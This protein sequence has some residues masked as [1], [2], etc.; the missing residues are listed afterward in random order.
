[1]AGGTAKLQE[2]AQDCM[3][4]E[5][6]SD[7]VMIITPEAKDEALATAAQK[8]MT[9]SLMNYLHEYVADNHQ[10]LAYLFAYFFCLLSWLI[11]YFLSCLLS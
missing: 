4:R 10:I 1:M 8:G 3:R 7:D 5:F 9:Q 6:H 2:N 11:A